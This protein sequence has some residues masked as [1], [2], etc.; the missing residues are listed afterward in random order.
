MDLRIE[1]GSADD[2]SDDARG[3]VFNRRPARA[4]HLVDDAIV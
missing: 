4:E 2:V 3:K 1:G